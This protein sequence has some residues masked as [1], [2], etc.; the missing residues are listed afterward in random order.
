[1]NEWKIRQELY[2][3]LNKNFSDDLKHF[4]IELTSNIVENAIRYFEE[5]DLGWIYP[6]KS[7]MVGICYAKWLSDNFGGNPF[8]YLNDSALLYNNDPYFVS[9]S[10]DP[11]TYHEILNKIGGW[12]FDETKGMVFD[13]KEYFKKEFML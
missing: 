1:M 11:K 10:S 2:H 3:R 5:K 9:Y 6:S 7:Y 12:N 13:V 4:N 8:E